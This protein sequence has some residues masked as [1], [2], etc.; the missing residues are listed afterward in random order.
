M[1]CPSCGAVGTMKRNGFNKGYI[2]DSEKGIRGWRIECVKSKH[3]NGCSRGWAVKLGD[4]VNQCCF[5]AGELWRFINQLG[6]GLSVKAAWEHSGIR[7]SLDTGYRMYKRL[8]KCQSIIRTHLRGR[9]PPPSGNAATPLFQMF[10]HLKKE[11]GKTEAV[12]QYQIRFQR[13]MLATS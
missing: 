5:T 10:D 11:C 2:S 9:S 12:S 1:T 4:T 13:S 8:L 3:R 6:K 7:M